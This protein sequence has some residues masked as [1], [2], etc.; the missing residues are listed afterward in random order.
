M[1]TVDPL[2]QMHAQSFE[3]IGADAG[4]H[5]RTGGG[6]IAVERVLIE[7]SHGEAGNRDVLEQHVTPA[8]HREGRVQFVATPGE[9]LKLRPGGGA[10]SRLVKPAS[11]ERQ[12]LV[13]ADDETSGNIR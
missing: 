7:P 4:G 8:S 13:G 3:L 2:E 10:I 6:E 12:G 1:V 11:A 5:G 9:R